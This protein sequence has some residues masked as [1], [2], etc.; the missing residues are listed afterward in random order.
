MTRSNHKSLNLTLILHH[1]VCHLEGLEGLPRLFI[2]RKKKIGR[3]SFF[4]R[5]SP[6]ITPPTP[7]TLQ[8]LNAPLPKYGR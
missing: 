5:S 4:F 1:T 6:E 8:I 3:S 2:N 7:Q